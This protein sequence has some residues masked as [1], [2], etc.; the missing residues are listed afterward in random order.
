MTDLRMKTKTCEI[1]KLTDSLIRDCIVKGVRDD[2]IR[3]RLLR[4]SS[5]TLWNVLDICQL[6]KQSSFYINEVAN[7]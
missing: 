7:N 2:N 3:S 1:G 6:T 5:L 4:E